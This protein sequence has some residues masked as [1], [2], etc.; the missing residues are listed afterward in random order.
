VV[1]GAVVAGVRQGVKQ[2]LRGVAA[3]AE[4]RAATP[5]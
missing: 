5:A 2:L 3:E 4:R 1:G